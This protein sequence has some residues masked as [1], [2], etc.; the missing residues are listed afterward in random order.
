MKIDVVYIYPLVDVRKYFMLAKRFAD[1]WRQY[2]P[3]V[4]CRL[5]V[6]CNGGE[7]NDGERRIFDGLDVRFCPRDNRAWDIGA[8]QDA[9]EN[10]LTDLLVCLGSYVHFHRDGWLKRMADAY[11]ENGP[12]L[13][14]CWGYLLPNWHVR[15]T[16]FWLHPE[17]LRS[18]PYLVGSVR[19]DRYKF[20]YGENSFTRHVLGLGLDCYMISYERTIPFNNWGEGTYA[21]DAKESLVLDQFT[22]FG[23]T[24]PKGPGRTK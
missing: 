22:N 19:Q 14:G 15:T 4:D 3:G 1:T 21:P 12:N 10:I 16:V 24:G 20:E 17:L 11:V 9:A 18:Y 13:Y 6:I 5:H 23:P 2:P 7:P 8:Y